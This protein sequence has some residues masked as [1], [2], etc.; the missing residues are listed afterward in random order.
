MRMTWSEEAEARGREQGE[1]RGQRRVLR[2]QLEKRFGP[3]TPAVQQ[4]LEEWP[5]ERLPELAEAVL[6][7]SSL[8]ELGLEE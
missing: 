7:A 6:E 8:R 5:P 2:I 4:R 1:M 3:L